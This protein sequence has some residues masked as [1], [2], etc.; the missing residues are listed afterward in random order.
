MDTRELTFKGDDKTVLYACGKCGRIASPGIYLANEE[1][2]H[3][4]ARRAAEECCQPYHCSDCGIETERYYTRCRTCHT[5]KQLQKATQIEPDHYTG[6]VCSDANSG[7]WGDGY[8]SSIEDLLD[9]CRDEGQEPPAYVFACEARPLAIDI[10]NLFVNL[11]EDRHES[12]ADAIVDGEELET[13]LKAWNAKQ[14]AIDYMEDRSTV[15]VLDRERFEALI[16]PAKE[17]T[18]ADER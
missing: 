1:K 14:T 13:F 5:R 12:V 4:A 8:S 16:A 15:I 17:S 7:G 3:A 9:I 18:D 10:E 2:R 6:P 11:T